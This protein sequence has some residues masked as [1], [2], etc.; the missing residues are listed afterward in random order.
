MREEDL[1]LQLISWGGKIF[2]DRSLTFGSKSSPGIYD[3]ISNIIRDIANL[4]AGLPRQSGFKCLDDTGHIHYKPQ[5]DKFFSEYKSLCEAVGVRLAPLGDKEKAFQADTEGT[6]LGLEYNTLKWTVSFCPRKIA[7]LE[8]LLTEA[9]REDRMELGRL[10]SLSGKLNHYHLVISP[11]GRWERGFIVYK[12]AEEGRN[13][14]LINVKMDQ[15]KDQVLWWLR[16]LQLC[17]EGTPIP[18]PFPRFRDSPFKLFPD[19][20]GASASNLKLGLGGVAWNIEGRPMMMYPWPERLRQKDASPCFQKKLTFLEAVAA[21]ATVT[22]VVGNMRG[23]SCVVYTDNVGLAHAW[24]RGHSRCWFTY[25]AMKA[26]AEVAFYMDV[27]VKVEWTR[28]CSSDPELVADLLSKGRWTEA[29]QVTGE[30]HPLMMRLSRTLAKWLH[31]PSATRVLGAAMCEE[32]SERNLMLPR[33][34]ESREAISM[35]LWS[36]EN[37]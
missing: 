22:G 11:K 26:L 27:Q 24:A 1:R 12:A 36:D 5:C 19:A 33:E 3:G 14:K 21:L 20:A 31:K 8:L 28:R 37:L 4:R 34:P 7:K 29:L 2:V 23:R 25:S 10:K 32:I 35:L 6:I 9:L 13:S 30:Q 15:L 17:K 18:D 16:N